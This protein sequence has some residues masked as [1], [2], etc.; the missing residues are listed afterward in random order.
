MNK[1]LLDTN[2]L[3]YALDQTSGFYLR[4]A[5]LLQDENV[6]LFTTTKLQL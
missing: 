5:A 2:I 1:V 3:I 6:R 4:A